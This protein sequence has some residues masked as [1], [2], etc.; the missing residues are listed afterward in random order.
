MYVNGS[1]SHYWTNDPLLAKC[2]SDVDDVNDF[3]VNARDQPRELLT[4]NVHDSH[5]IYVPDPDCIAVWIRS[6]HEEMK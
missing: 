2:F 5:K 6:V 3:L 1:T 4:G